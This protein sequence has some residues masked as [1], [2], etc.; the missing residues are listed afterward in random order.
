M[1][2]FED[3]I[4]ELKKVTNKTEDEIISFVRGQELSY[5]QVLIFYLKFVRFPTVD[6]SKALF[7]M[8]K[9]LFGDFRCLLDFIENKQTPK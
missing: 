5:N 4:Q 2:Y 6:E 3:L 9:T 7:A 8:T 1:R